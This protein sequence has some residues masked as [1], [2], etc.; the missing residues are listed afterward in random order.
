MSHRDINLIYFFNCG[1]I[2]FIINIYSNNQQNIL[3]YLKD[4]EVNLS[5]IFIMTK[6]FNIRDNNWNLSYPHY[7]VYTD[8]MITRP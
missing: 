8:V 4:I 5:S 7:S 3:K 6:D 1:F 2:C